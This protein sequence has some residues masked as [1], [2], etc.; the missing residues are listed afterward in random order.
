MFN[1][2]ADNAMKLMTYITTTFHRINCTFL[3][4]L[5]EI[6][7]DHTLGDEIA[8]YVH[9]IHVHTKKIC[10]TIQHKWGDT[11]SDIMAK[12]ECELSLVYFGTWTFGEYG[13]T[14]YSKTKTPEITD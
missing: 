12:C 11:E 10:W 7:S 4:W 8:L 9:H 1:W 2:A 6:K 5:G 13:K 3:E 14:N